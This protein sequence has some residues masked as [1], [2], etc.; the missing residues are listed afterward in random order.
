M[1]FGKRQVEQVPREPSETVDL[2]PRPESSLGTIVLICAAVAVVGAITYIAVSKEPAN[3]N[4]SVLASKPAPGRAS[5]A[6][7]AK[8]VDKIV[9]HDENGRIDTEVVYYS[10]NVTERREFSYNAEGKLERVTSRSSDGKISV[11]I[12]H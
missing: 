6:A 10:N 1:S 8:V 7:P 12:H 5:K 4:S 3:A 9:T 11:T 2:M